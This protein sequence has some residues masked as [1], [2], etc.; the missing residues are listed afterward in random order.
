MPEAAP[1]D[2]ANALPPPRP[3]RRRWLGGVVAVLALLALGALAWYLAH[4][5][6]VP[7]GV[8]GAAAG[9]PGGGGRAGGPGGGRGGPASTVG[10]AAATTRDMP[11]ILDAL[12]TVTPVVTVT[13]RPQVSGIITQVFFTEGQLVSKGQL[14][15]QIDP[16][17]FDIALQQA[18]GARL[19]DE[20]QLENARITLQRYQTLLQQDSIA[21]QDVDTQA[22]LVKQLEG[23]VTMDKANEATARLNVGYARV[24]APSA[25]RIGLRPVDPGNNISTGDANGVATIT[26]VAPIDVQFAVPQDRVPEIQSRVSEG[27]RLPVTAWD[28]TRT[29]KLGEGTFSTLDNLVDVTTGTVK[30]KAR[31]PNTDTALFPNQ[32]VNV[33]ILLRTIPNAVVVPVTALR[34]GSNGDFVYVLQEDRTVSVRPVTRGDQTVDVVAIASGLQPGE[35]VVTEGGDRLKEGARVQVAGDRPVGAA[36]GPMR[37]AS[38]ARGRSG[39]GAAGPRDGAS[40]PRAGWAGRRASGA[41]SQAGEGS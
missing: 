33:Q 34:H 12:G 37:G 32:F 29:R 15:A 36:S 1:S 28:R 2:H 35:R 20:A 17:P 22:A 24:V 21:R 3:P 41:A 18:I 38:G 9:G 31:F 10:I 39:D 13:V 11:V 5:P 14:L 8:A 6:A 27:A 30:A 23:T 19:R 16:R 26:Q 7:N 25:G 40:G 4:R